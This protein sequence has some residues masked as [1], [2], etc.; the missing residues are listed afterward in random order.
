MGLEQL[1]L[2]NMADATP[3]PSEKPK[4]L[5]ATLLLERPAAP[6]YRLL[7]ER[8]GK[9]LDFNLEVA[10]AHKAEFPML[11]PVDGDMVIGLRVD[12]PFSWPLE[13][14]A[15][16]AYWWPDAM[17]DIARSTCF[18]AITCSWSRHS[19]LEAHI[20]HLVLVRELVEQLPVIGVVWGSVLVQPSVLKAEFNRLQDSE[21]PFSLWVLIQF[22]KQPN[23]NILI[24]TL[25]MRDFGQME[26]ETEST[27]SLDETFDLVRKFGSYILAKGP[28][29]KDSETF[30]LTETQRI[31]VR[32]VRSFRPDVND[33]VYWLELAEQPSVQRP[34][35]FFS[36]LF[37]SDRKQ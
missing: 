8:I 24:S 32:F 33:N 21:L 14:L 19:R 18:A 2:S 20:R 23:G 1:G 12:A 26:I 34:T 10:L 22:S 27:L 7:A 30:G 4:P 3:T 11:L 5:I 35:G 37:G 15:Q 29:V 36:K 16:F 6:D 31:R 28:V 9:P 25:G 17:E 13:P